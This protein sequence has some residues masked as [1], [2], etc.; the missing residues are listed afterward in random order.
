M[1]FLSK[2]SS[3]LIN[4]CSLNKI[5]DIITS[6]AKDLLIVTPNMSKMLQKYRFL[7][8]KQALNLK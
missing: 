2:L 1:L 3:V 4:Y 6:V 8:S 5:I 7:I